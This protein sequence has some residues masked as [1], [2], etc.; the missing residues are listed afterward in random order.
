MKLNCA[1]EVIVLVSFP[2]LVY[3]LIGEKNFIL[4]GEFLRE[5]FTVF[6]CIDFLHLSSQF[7]KLFF[8]FGVGFA[9]SFVLSDEIVTILRIHVFP[10]GNVVAVDLRLNRRPNQRHF[11]GVFALILYVKD[12]QNAVRHYDN[13]IFDNSYGLPKA[14]LKVNSGVTF[15]NNGKSMSIGSVTGTG[16]LGGSGTYTIGGNNSNMTVN[17]T[18]SAPIVKV[19]EGIMM[20][21]TAGNLKSTV[22]IKEGALYF[23]NGETT[24][25]FGGA[26]TVEGTGVVVGSGLVSSMTLKNGAQLTPRSLF[27][28]DTFGGIFPGTVK[29]SAAMNFQQGSTLNIIIQGTTTDDYSRL[30]PRFLTMN[31]TVKVTLADGYT[32]KVGDTFTLWSASG[33]FS[34]TPVYDLPALPEGLFWNTSSLAAMEGVLTIT[35]DATVGVGQLSANA[36][37]SCEVYTITGI[38]LGTFQTRRSAIPGQV[39]KLGVVAGT[40]LV[41]MTAGRN[42]KTETVVIR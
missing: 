4:G 2:R 27:L 20:V 13:F 6:L 35:D 5:A 32:P 15:D 12:L 38:R 30:T 8:L 19:G 11:V 26:L 3:F 31:G 34:G 29:S 28:E 39:K 23:D 37:V 1:V 7:G 33:T 36:M 14:T 41:K 21:N 22:T 10:F 17:F 9:K 24:A 40:Y 42:T 16:T 18:S 25:L